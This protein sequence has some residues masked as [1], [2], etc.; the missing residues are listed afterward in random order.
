MGKPGVEGV[1]VGTSVVGI[2]VGVSGG[3]GVSVGVTGVLV[4]SCVSVGVIGV[5]VGG[6]GVRLGGTAVLVGM[7]VG[8]GRRVLVGPLKVGNRNAVGV[9]GVSEAVGLDVI[10]GRR[11]RVAVGI[12]SAMAW[13]VNAPA[14]FKLLTAESTI[15]SGWKAPAVPDAFKSWIAIPETE[16]SRLIPIAPA[17]KTARRPR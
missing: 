17:T 11:V 10:V 9:I 4:G 1:S 5:F 8:R 15:F 3:I 13:R 2:V 6:G 12:N 7:S 16:H 14:V